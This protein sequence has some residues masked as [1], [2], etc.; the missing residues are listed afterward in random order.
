MWL[1]WKRLEIHTNVR[2]ENQEDNVDVDM[3]ITLKWML[4]S[5]IGSGE[6]DT[7]VSAQQ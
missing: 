2:Y 7:T 4:K 3:R 5:K 1:K 6:L